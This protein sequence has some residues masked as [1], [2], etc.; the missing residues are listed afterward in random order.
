MQNVDSAG[1]YDS[2]RRYNW[3][4]EKP[5]E[6]MEVPADFKAEIIGEAYTKNALQT[7]PAWTEWNRSYYNR[8]RIAPP[9]KITA[10]HQ[11]AVNTGRP[12]ASARQYSPGYYSDYIHENRDFL[13]LKLRVTVGSESLETEI[14]MPQPTRGGEIDLSEKSLDHEIVQIHNFYGRKLRHVHSV[15]HSNGWRNYGWDTF[16]WLLAYPC[17]QGTLKLWDTFLKAQ[18]G[19]LKELDDKG[20]KAASNHK[21]IKPNLLRLKEEQPVLHRFFLWLHNG[22]TVNKISNNSLLSAMLLECGK[23]FDKLKAELER[24]MDLIVKQARL[25]HHLPSVIEGMENDDEESED[26]L[27]EDKTLA[28]DRD[29]RAICLLFSASKEKDRERRETHEWYL[30][31]SNGAK[32]EGLGV[33]KDKHPLF[34]AAVS[35]GKIPLT[36]FHNPGKQLELTNIEFDLWEKAFKREGWA[37]PLSAISNNAS[38][39][40]TYDKKVTPYISFLFKIEQYLNKHCPG[41]TSWK[42]IPK[43]VATQ[44][45][46][47]MEEEVKEG[48]TAKKRSALTPVADNEARTI[49]VP[50]AGIAVYG[51]QTTYCYSNEYFVFEEN[52]VDPEGGGVVVRDL[53]E[54]LNGRDDY[55]LM[56]YTLDG[57]PRNQGYPTFLIIFEQ[58][59]VGPFVHFH[60]VHPNRYKN[61]IPTPACRLI[62]ECYRYMAGNIRAEEIHGQQGDLMFIKTDTSSAQQEEKKAIL[63]FE[64]HVFAAKDKSPIYLS[65]NTNKSINNRLGFIHATSEFEVQHP[66]HEW[67]TFSAGIYE[68]R[69]CKSYE[70]NPVAVWSYTID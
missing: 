69:R 25:A 46:L 42:A 13:Y 1:G 2:G 66:E 57:T 47:E 16:Y 21:E 23:D 54:K 61:G 34:Y 22:K 32:A 64:S 51:R 35:E 27:E 53:E 24:V 19:Q 58:R 62:E 10:P 5:L 60:R 48:Q 9:E 52:M 45:E 68:V 7:N 6:S 3:Y 8:A 36:L 17:K 20:I 14:C 37:E 50:Y 43:F 40:S 56:F 59:R 65:G 70:N 63:D 38:R 41:K 49:T 44:W 30:R 12:L 33:S 18:L 55:G 26:D 28:S 31:K 11:Y 15:R 29:G 67:L 39:R 4:V